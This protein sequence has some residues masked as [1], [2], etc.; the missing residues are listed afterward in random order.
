MTGVQT[1]ALPISNKKFSYALIYLGQREE[2]KHELH[3][4]RCPPL[5]KRERVA[6]KTADSTYQKRAQME[7][8][9]RRKEKKD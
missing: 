5:R 4:S 6:P 2:K 7:D 3:E 1:C 9:A 8:G